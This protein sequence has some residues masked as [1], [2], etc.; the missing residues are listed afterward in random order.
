MGE[1]QDVV[2]YINLSKSAKG[3]DAHILRDVAREE[4]IHAKHLKDMLQSAGKL[5]DFSGLEEQ[6]IEALDGV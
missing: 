5:Q 3:G 4:F 1:Y 2:T 6:A